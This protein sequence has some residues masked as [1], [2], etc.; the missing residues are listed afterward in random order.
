MSQNH[1]IVDGKVFSEV[2]AITVKRRVEYFTYFPKPLPSDINYL[3][4]HN[5]S[6][7]TLHCFYLSLNFPEYIEIARSLE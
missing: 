1:K 2:Q 4:S 7:S 5:L 3:Q 6:S